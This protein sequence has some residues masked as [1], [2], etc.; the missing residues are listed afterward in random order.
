M[1]FTNVMFFSGSICHEPQFTE[2]DRQATL[3][4]YSYQDYLR[5]TSQ[6]LGPLLS[7]HNFVYLMNKATPVYAHGKITMVLHKPLDHQFGKD[8]EK[9]EAKL[10][11]GQEVGSFTRTSSI[12][13]NP[14]SFGLPAQCRFA[15][16]TATRAYELRTGET[17]SELRD[18]PEGSVWAHTTAMGNASS[19]IMKADADAFVDRMVE[20]LPDSP[21]FS[22]CDCNSFHTS[23]Y[24]WGLYAIRAL[25]ERDPQDAVAILNFDQHPDVGKDDPLGSDK[26]GIPLLSNVQNG[27]YL[28]IGNSASGGPGLDAEYKWTNSIIVR[29]AGATTTLSSQKAKEAVTACA[30]YNAMSNEQKLNYVAGV[31]AS[32]LVSKWRRLPGG[33]ASDAEISEL[34]YGMATDSLVRIKDAANFPLDLYALDINSL[35]ALFWKNLR[36]HLGRPVKYVFITIDRDVI[37]GH[38]TQWGDN[39]FIPNGNT[40]I[41]TMTSVYDALAR[42]NPG[43]KIIGV[44][45]TGLPESRLVYQAQTGKL[46]PAENAWREA[47]DQIEKV[48]AWSNHY[49]A[50]QWWNPSVQ[51]V[52][53]MGIIFDNLTRDF[54]GKTLTPYVP[55]SVQSQIMAFWMQYKPKYDMLRK[56]QPVVLATSLRPKIHSQLQTFADALKK[57]STPQGYIAKQTKVTL[58][59][60]ANRIA[61]VLEKERDRA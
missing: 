47:R 45:I 43:S 14:A 26:W 13:S 60:Y 50:Q 6:R 23:G 56:G 35:F 54:R 44:D 28:S 32:Q 34:R 30:D 5:C 33:E 21:V 7:K 22:V 4:D 11:A 17:A 46:L 42:K 9:L 10:G 15:Q 49:L 16:N 3:R 8:K 61:S 20:A 52:N 41:R 1:A 36:E 58:N 53:S 39:S 57:A 24:I 12:F 25:R 40:L 27:C 59:A 38:H 18:P 19:R 37:Q 31:L 51:L 55:S 29:R 2:R 48:Y